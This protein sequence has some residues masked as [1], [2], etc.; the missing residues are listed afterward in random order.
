MV[1]ELAQ[2][3]IDAELEGC[4]GGGGAAGGNAASVVLESKAAHVQLFLDY[5]LMSGSA[6]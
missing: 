1:K 3:M 6:A 5:N 4:A 2:R